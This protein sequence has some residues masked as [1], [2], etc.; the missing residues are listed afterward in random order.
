MGELDVVSPAVRVV[1]LAAAL[2]MMTPMT[3]SRRLVI[4]S[5][6][7]LVAGRLG[8]E[9]SDLV[10]NH[11]VHLVSVKRNKDPERIGMQRVVMI[12]DICHHRSATFIIVIFADG[13]P[14]ALHESS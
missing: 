13:H 4:F 10:T 8:S 3:I 11:I 2:V 7:M 1:E 5:E 12:A 9:C 14:P 6:W